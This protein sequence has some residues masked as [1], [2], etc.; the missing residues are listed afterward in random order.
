MRSKPGNKLKKIRGL[1]GV[2]SVLLA[3]ALSGCITDPKRKPDCVI[4]IN[5]NQC[6]LLTDST[7]TPYY[8]CP[9]DDSAKVC[10]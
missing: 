6:F 8:S 1:A 7:G 5:G 2:V 9:F 4:N 10:K 3:A